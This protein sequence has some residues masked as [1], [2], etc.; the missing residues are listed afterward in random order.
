MLPI[1]VLIVDDDPSLCMLMRRLV[2][3]SYPTARVTEAPNGQAALV[4]YETVGADLIITDIQM[5][6]LDGIALTAAVRTR[7]GLLPII[8]VSGIP[9]G[10]ALANQAG[11]SRYLHKDALTTQLAH[12]LADISAI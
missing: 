8:V 9:D 7:D 6:I 11:A 10:E 1:H 4:A 5:P 12:V 2:L 3:R